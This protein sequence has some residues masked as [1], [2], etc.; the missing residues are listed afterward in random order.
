MTLSR[1]YLWISL[2]ALMLAAATVLAGPPQAVSE[3][4]SYITEPGKYLLANDLFC[5]PGVTPIKILA[6]DVMLDLRGHS[7]NCAVGDRSG[8][9]VGDDGDQEVFSN[10]RITNGSING[11]GVGALLWFTDGARVT[12]M[13]FSGSI[14]S[15]VTLVEAQ[16]NVIKNNE[17][18]GDFWAINSYASTG[19]SYS[20]NTIRYSVV[21][22]DLYAETDSRITCNT[23]D[24]G[25]FTL[26][27]GPYGPWPSSG[28]L[29]RGNLVTGSFLGI[30]MVG[31]GTPDDG[32]TDPQS[33]D[34]LI[35]ANVATG[36]W[37]DMAEAL[38]NPYTDELFVEPGAACAN[39]W[40]NNQ[41]YWS[42]GPPDCIGTPI[43]L[44]EVC[45]FEGDDD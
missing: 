37:W 3:C 7:I 45:A 42:L 35:H 29:V 28:N 43:D 9:V 13:S 30:A 32:V 39:T 38:Y 11:C 22:I 17:F 8:V 21:G 36:N 14:E 19:N 20:H 33:I 5:D 1:N 34:N 4:G 10:V 27:L 25:Y 6:S 15:G 40:K 23:V 16:N 18:W 26:S 2:P 44:D 12:K 31:Y 24:Q 41:F